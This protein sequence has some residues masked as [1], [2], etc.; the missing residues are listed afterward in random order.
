MRVALLI[1][2][3]ANFAVFVWLRWARPFAPAA[4]TGLVPSPT[5][6]TRLRLLGDKASPGAGC[7]LL[8]PG[9]NAK[10]ARALAARLRVHGYA[11]RVAARQ[12]AAPSGYWVLLAGFA[13][14]EAA[15]QAAARLRQGGIRDLFLLNGSSGGG[16]SISLG[17][18]QDLADARRRAEHAQMLGFQPRIRERFRSAPRWYV[19]VPAPT[20]ATTLAS[21]SGTVVQPAA[22]HGA[23]KSGTRAG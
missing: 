21:I 3:L 14:V 13:N 9:V 7:L 20:D 18:F 8:G 5:M 6:A 19:Q 2:V 16:A 11:A 22:C 4:D 17:L 1:L 12:A 23:A 10:A 15:R